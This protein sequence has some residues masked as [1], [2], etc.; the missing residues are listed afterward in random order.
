MAAATKKV[1]MKHAA[2]HQ[3]EILRRPVSINDQTKNAATTTK[4]SFAIEDDAEF[5]YKSAMNPDSRGCKLKYQVTI[6]PTMART[7]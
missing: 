6:S 4:R 3:Y 2:H 5:V 7:K 1:N